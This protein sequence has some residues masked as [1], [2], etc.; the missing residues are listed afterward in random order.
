MVRKSDVCFGNLGNW[1][2]SNGSNNSSE[3][4]INNIDDF[5]NLNLHNAN[6]NISAIN[7]IKVKK[8]NF[9]SN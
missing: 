5:S 1:N 8:E 2:N 4:I 7:N 6:C 9:K 3:W